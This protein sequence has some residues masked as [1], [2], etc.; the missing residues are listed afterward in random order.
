MNKP[1]FLFVGKSA[2]GKTTIADMLENQY[3]L[4]QTRSYTTRPPRYDGEIAHTFITDEE[5]DR[6]EDIVAYT[7]YN[8]FR[9][10][11]TTEQIDNVSIYVVDVPGVTTLLN[12][13][14]TERPIVVFYFDASICTRIDRMMERNDSDM[15]IVSRL[16]T[17]ER[18]DWENE[19]NKLVWHYKNNMSR[20]ISMRTIDANEDIKYVLGKITNFINDEM[21]NAL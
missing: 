12:K 8:G 19:L 4:V 15:S 16:Y 7:E 21:E 1:L 14:Q 18:F 13:Y 2:S 17:D 20:N 5:F 10:C 9:Y 3:G 11:A 6:L